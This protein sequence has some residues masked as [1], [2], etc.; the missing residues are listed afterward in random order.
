MTAPERRPPRKSAANQS[1]MQETILTNLAARSGRSIEEWVALYLRDAPNDRRVDAIRW[2]KAEHGVGG[3]T[4]DLIIARAT[5]SSS[6][7]DRAP[8]SE[9]IDAQYAGKKA[10]LRPIYDRIVEFAGTLGDDIG[11]SAAK[12]LVTIRRARQ[13]AV[14]WA[15]PGRVELGLALPGVKPGGRLQAVKSANDAD[16][17][18]VYVALEKEAD[19]DREVE[20]WL[21]QAYEADALGLSARESAALTAAKP[22]RAS[23]KRG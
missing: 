8:E 16:R 4:A 19:F 3:V 20:N 1:A 15:K 22:S 21:R 17:V 9:A 7:M 10:A 14:I 12:T 6:V 11:I 2:F 13:I 18:R 23:L 5:G